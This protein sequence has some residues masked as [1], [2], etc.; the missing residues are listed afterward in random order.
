MTESG[1][2]FVVGLTAL[3][4]LVGLCFLVVLFGY[5]PQMLERSYVVTVHL[6][7]AGGLNR[8][9][10]V[11]LSGLDI[12]RIEAIQLGDDAVNGVIVQALIRQDI[13]IPRDATAM[14]AGQLFSGSATLSFD[15][16]RLTPEQRREHLPTDGSAV[17]QGQVRSFTSAFA[18]ALAEPTKNLTRITESFE[19]LAL[20]WNQ[21]GENVNAMLEHRDAAAVDRGE[22]QANLATVLQRT[23]ADLAELKTTLERINAIL[24]DEKLI[25][26]LKQTVAGAAALPAKYA[27]VA[28]Q[29]AVAVAAMGKAI[30]QA[31]AGDGTV[32]RLMS[33]PALYDNLND[34]AQRLGTALSE[35]NNL[36]VKMRNEGLPLKFD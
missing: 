8:A 15:T 32:G 35:L 20:Q 12:G 21:V 31:R 34:A 23:D 9:N 22:V 11:T 13:R 5:V 2:N 36:L 33:D 10:R 18:E 24:G 3:C 6:P 1:R 28:D 17:L 30:D 14:V 25:G 29:L 19:T 16:T 4:G 27:H 7:N 26:D